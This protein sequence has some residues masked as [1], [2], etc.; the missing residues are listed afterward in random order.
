MRFKWSKTL[1]FAQKRCDIVETLLCQT[2]F[3][4]YTQ[5][6]SWL[7]NFACFD[8]TSTY[9]FFSHIFNMNE[10]PPHSLFSLLFIF[11]KLNEN[12]II[13]R[14]SNDFCIFSKNNIFFK[15]NS[16]SNELCE[17]LASVVTS[18]GLEMFALGWRGEPCGVSQDGRWSEWFWGVGL[19]EPSWTTWI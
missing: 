15:N 5:K 3:A 2:R 17:R 14:C 1:P 4:K 6:R 9:L 19:W 12:S 10:N 8:Q 7:T 13:Y 11:F 16:T 18:V